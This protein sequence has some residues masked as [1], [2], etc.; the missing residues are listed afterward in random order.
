M[1]QIVSGGGF[2]TW[3]PYQDSVFDKLGAFSGRSWRINSKLSAD[4]AHT[5]FS[6]SWFQDITKSSLYTVVIGGIA[7]V[8][9]SFESPPFN[10]HYNIWPQVPLKVK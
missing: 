7:R 6:T 4:F 2:A 3:T 5:I 8:C 10:I 1:L 9:T